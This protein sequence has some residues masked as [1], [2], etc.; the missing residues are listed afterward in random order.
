MPV[1]SSSARREA[2]SGH[3]VTGLTI[4]SLFSGV[5]GLDMAVE[6]FFGA[7]PSWFVEFDQA[8]SKV[9]A[10]RWPGVPNFGD[11]TTVDWATVPRVDILT[12]GFPCQDLSLI[13]R[14]AGMRPGT[15]SGLWADYL[16]AIAAIKPRM[17]VIENVKGLLSGAAESDSDLELGPGPLGIS[18]GGPVLRALGRVL[19]DLAGIGYDARWCG[20]LAA[21]A[22]APHNRFRVFVAAYPRGDQPELWRGSADVARSPGAGQSV[23]LGW[24]RVRAVA[25]NRSPHDWGK[26]RSAIERWE[27]I[28]G[29]PAPSP[30]RLDELAGKHWLSPE[31][32]EW[33]MGWPEGHVTSPDIWAGT[34]MTYR[35][36]EDAKAKIC[37]NGVVPQQAFAALAVLL[38][39]PS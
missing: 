36:I 33:M 24:Q 21:H 23:A 6:R 13:G 12:G 8:P 31:F 15:R 30:T 39:R 1:W 9:L 29:R 37:G 4:G 11:V 19:G 16:A 14:R 34:G 5:G 32:E 38:G 7:K 35:A 3:I 17:V 10:H 25:G 2:C 20:L 27:D 28:L 26:H 22:G 18:D